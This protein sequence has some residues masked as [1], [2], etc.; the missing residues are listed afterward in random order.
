MDK[1]IIELNGVSCKVGYRHL[2]KDV[3]WQVMPGEHWAVF[4][5]NGSGKTTLLSIIAGFRERTQGELKIFGEVPTN[6]TILDVRKKIGWVSAAFFDQ[7]YTKESVLDIVLSGKTGTLGLA[8]D[9]DLDE[10]TLAK[11]LLTELQLG[12]KIDRSFDMLSKGERQN[13]LIAR[14]LISEPDILILDEPC[15]GL[16]VYNRSYLFSIIEELSANKAL[17]IIYVTHYVEELIPLFD[18]M[19]IL[20]NG[21]VFAQGE[22]A[23]LMNNKTMAGLLGYPVQVEKEADGYRMQVATKSRIQAILQTRGGQYDDR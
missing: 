2:L 5:M 9:I 17:T 6:T 8:S 19:L 11:A 22:T 4:G 7:Y 23:N 16:D 14:A 1:P 21:A 12:D 3:Q 10:V 13:V 15:T 20:K 18:K